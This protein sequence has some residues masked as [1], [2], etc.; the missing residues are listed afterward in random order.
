M[1]I[2]VLGPDINESNYT[3]A[4]NKE[5]AIRFGL[6]AIK[7]LG[8]GPVDAIVKER[9]NGVYKSI[10][11][12]TKR[13]NLR[14]CNKKAFESL[15]YAGGFDSFTN[16]HRAQ[17][18]TADSSG[19]TF[20]E[21]AVKFGAA[22]QESQ[23]SAQAS[24]FG[25]SSET[26]LPEPIIPKA[27]EWTSIYKLNREKEVVGIFISGHPLDDFKID[28]DSFCTGNIGMLNEMQEHLQKDLFIAAVVTGAEHRLTKNGDPFGT[29]VIEDYN[30]SHRLNLFNE[31]YLK[32]KHFMEP[33]I[34]IVMKGKVQIS[35]KNRT[36]PEFAV[37]TIELLQELRDKRTKEI[38]LILNNK[39]VNQIF[40]SE[41]NT[42]FVQYPGNTPVTIKVLD[43]LEGV[44]VTMKSRSLRVKASNEFLDRLSELMIGYTL[45]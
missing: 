16:V 40:I 41:L 23:F 35:N 45:N 38:N 27:E 28:I 13:V 37:S 43:A 19:R 11:D 24:I 15:A 33:G 3:F 26:S 1:G 42:M 21:S 10:F 4:V 20:L 25:G 22:F 18:F 29:L 9:K 12:L 7:G 17:Y 5:G 44:E 6:G 14:V 31:N 34:F 2:N 39:N 36:Q 30:D 8:S 32:F